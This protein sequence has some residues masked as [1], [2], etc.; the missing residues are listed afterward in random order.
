MIV[1]GVVTITDE[2]YTVKDV[3]QPMHPACVIDSR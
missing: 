3:N 1:E 2:F